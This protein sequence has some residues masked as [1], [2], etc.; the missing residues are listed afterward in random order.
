MPRTIHP[1]LL[2]AL[3]PDHPDAIH[4]R[5]DLRFINR[6]MGNHRWIARE[7]PRHVRANDRMLEIGAGTG[8]LA[9]KLS[10]AGFA[11]DALDFVPPPPNW[12]AALM[13]HQADL[14]TFGDYDQ[15][16]MIVGNLIFHHLTE[17]ELGELG[18]RL[19]T[20]SRV[21]I[22][23]EPVRRR[24]SQLMFRAFAPIFGASHVTVHDGLVSIAG[25]F[26]S[27]ELPCALGLDNDRWIVDQSSSLFGGYRMV[28]T[29]RA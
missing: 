12:P 9:L 16:G 10:R 3:P 18:A 19:R 25:G 15:Y 1:E 27:D 21:I 29:R 2:D 22:A 14:K 23:C 11:V 8:E 5:R 6:F 20:S 24:F 13:W 4:S 26:A 7:L 28:A 17:D